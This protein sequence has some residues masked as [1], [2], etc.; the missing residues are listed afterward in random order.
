MS[1]CSTDILVCMLTFMHGYK[2]VFFVCRDN[3]EKNAV[4]SFL[5]IKTIVKL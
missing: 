1:S 4:M 5:M 2:N 3:A